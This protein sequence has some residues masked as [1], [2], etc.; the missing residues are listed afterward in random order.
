[1]YHNC[2]CDSE[3]CIAVKKVNINNTFCENVT[4]P[5]F[6]KFPRKQSPSSTIS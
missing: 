6:K 5:S 4:K 3:F 2:E 1:M